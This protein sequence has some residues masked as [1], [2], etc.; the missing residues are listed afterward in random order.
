M[1]SLLP[2]G[3]VKEYLEYKAEEYAVVKLF[4]KNY[5]PERRIK[6]ELFRAEIGLLNADTNSIRNFL[7]KLGKFDLIT[8]LGKTW[9]RRYYKS[10]RKIGCKE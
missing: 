8:A 9:V 1:R 10:R 4:Q 2:H 5:T 6:R 7:K 3:K